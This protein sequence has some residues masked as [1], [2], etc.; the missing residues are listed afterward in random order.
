MPATPSLIKIS[1]N[2]CSRDKVMHIENDLGFQTMGAPSATQS[3]NQCLDVKSFGNL[4]CGPFQFLDINSF[5]RFIKYISAFHCNT[6]L[7]PLKR[8]RQFRQ[9][10]NDKLYTLKN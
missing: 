10:V 7:H 2:K 3:N 1:E 8:V 6:F 4:K 5:Q 9:K